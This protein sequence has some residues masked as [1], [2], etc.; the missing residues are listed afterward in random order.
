MISRPDEALLRTRGLF[1][2]A[3]SLPRARLAQLVPLVPRPRHLAPAAALVGLDTL[4]LR[5]YLFTNKAAGGVDSAFLYSILPY[6]KSH[7]LGAFSVW[8]SAPFGEVQQY[9]V[10]WFLASLVGVVGHAMAVYKL[11][12][13][14]AVLGSSVSSYALA[15]WLTRSELA[16]GVAAFLYTFSPFAVA[17]GLAGHL[18]VEI[19]Y[20][21]GPLAVW[22]LWLSLRERRRRAMIGLGL[23]G[24]A[25]FLLTTGQGVYWLLPLT[26]V[27]GME[28]TVGAARGRRA[29]TA[30]LETTVVGGAAFTSASAVQILPSLFGARAPYVANSNGLYISQLSIHAKYS[31][32]FMDGLLGVPR[33]VY[34]SGAQTIA[35]APFRAG[36]FEIAG[37][38]LVVLA[39]VSL[40]V[41]SF[42]IAA[43]LILSAVAAWLLAAG[44]YGPVHHVYLL[45]YSHFPY[46]RLLRVPNRW[47]MVSGLAVSTCTGLSLA[48]I[49]R[50]RTG[51]IRSPR[52][53]AR[54]LAT[55]VI[56]LG[57]AM[58][59]YGLS[60]GFPA[61]TLPKP[62]A[63]SY[64]PL[65]SDPGEW[66]ILTSPFWQAWMLAGKRF[67][68]HESLTADLGFTSSVWHHHAVVGRGGW[69][70]RAARFVRYLYELTLQGTNTSMTKLL[71]AA[72]V[73]YIALENQSFHEVLP[74][75][76][77][78]FARQR[79][80]KPVAA[81]RAQPTV[82]H[83]TKFLPEA[84]VARSS[85]VVAGG[86][87]TLGDLALQSEVS[88]ARTSFLFADQVAALSGKTGLRRAIRASGCLILA[89]GGRDELAVLLG[90]VSQAQLANT[91]PEGWGRLEMNPSLDIG[92]EPDL[93]VDTPPGGQIR[94][95]I[96]APGPG[97]Y[98]LF[99]SALHA[100]NQ[101]ELLIRVDGHLV[102]KIDLTTTGGSGVLWSRISIPHLDA[103]AHDVSISYPAHRSEINAHLASVALVPASAAGSVLNHVPHAVT[104][105]H[106]NGG[107]G[108]IDGPSLLEAP[109]GPPLRSASWRSLS[110]ARYVRA[111]STTKGA[112]VLSVVRGGRKYYT[113]VDA[114]VKH[115][116]NP[117][118][119]I[120][121]RFKGTGSGRVF[122]LNFRFGALGAQ[123]IGYRFRDVSSA[124]RTIVFSPLQPDFQTSV[125][126]WDLVRSVSLS[127]ANRKPFTRPILVEGPFSLS[128]SLAPR[129]DRP[130]LKWLA[131]AGKGST[132]ALRNPRA[133][134][135]DT[136]P[137]R[138]TR[139][140]VLIY[141]QSYNPGWSLA[142]TQEGATHTIALGFANAYVVPHAVKE[143]SLS[144]GPAR[145]GRIAT[146]LSAAA[147]LLLL[148]V[149]ITGGKRVRRRSRSVDG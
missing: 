57:L 30:L 128:R 26:C 44:P 29:A 70:P 52:R 147:W 133:P 113:L 111:R 129:F 144:F 31:L 93:E 19:S 138:P 66:R 4:I 78:F 108:P 104:L 63:K 34:L 40:V 146:Y 48:S 110:P 64:S 71:G 83:V 60:N 6:F 45:L 102:G 24:S 22:L 41:S 94:A 8:L 107:A 97:H 137:L 127:V 115:A 7:G 96:V 39:A 125:P 23:A 82:L 90:A 130:G 36:P 103:G 131:R 120:A 141:T 20:A 105:I 98:V 16:A 35:A 85:C 117:Y 17:Q 77:E 28:L 69:D 65:A 88:F 143:S 72:G 27:A 50:L 33:E 89:P 84:Y 59:S 145:L 42:R 67:N 18:N 81:G 3:R 132:I 61:W 73:K 10:Y 32:P 74:G 118:R 121:I 122:Y 21:V 114:P 15:Y 68:R 9:S 14:L 51:L 140:G 106:E 53:L 56:V 135:E 25:L 92:A 99:L 100:N 119:P 148:W 95:P 49:Q 62:Y 38:T 142:P 112:L 54:R 86:L 11:S 139:S 101:R 149:T 55:L 5:N 123:R 43:A 75:Q 116:V 12:V 136:V 13:F 91:A 80:L 46:F 1:S 79:F 2:K 37:F 134:I 76:N 124:L 47:L 87:R 109:T 58:G 126:R